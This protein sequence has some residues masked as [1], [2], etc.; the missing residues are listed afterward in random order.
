LIDVGVAGGGVIFTVLSA[1][2]GFGRL[3]PSRF[4]HRFPRLAFQ[5]AAVE[6]GLA[7]LRNRQSVAVAM[8]TLIIYVPDALSLWFVV[9]AFGLELGL[10]DTLV[11]VG[12]ASLSTLLPSD[13]AYLGTLQLAYGLAIEFAG[14]PAAIGVAAATLAQLCILLPVAVVAIA[15]FTHGSDGPLYVGL[16]QSGANAASPSLK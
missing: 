6:R 3:R 2:L 7:I 9:K 4:C 12:A 5:L 16:A 8:L 10:P 11:L 13:P 14:G 15:I 1:T